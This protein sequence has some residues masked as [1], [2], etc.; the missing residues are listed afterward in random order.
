[1]AVPIKNLED[2]T[3]GDDYKRPLEFVDKNDNPIDITGATVYF[4]LRKCIPSSDIITDNDSDVILKKDITVHTDP[5]N[6]KTELVLTDEDT[7]GLELGKYFYDIQLKKANG[8]I[9]TIIKGQLKIVWDIT[10]RK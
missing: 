8:E 3:R 10:R 7:N 4:T 5:V 1:M 2:I 6:G 9:K